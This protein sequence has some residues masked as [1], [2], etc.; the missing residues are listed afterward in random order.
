[1]RGVILELRFEGVRRFRLIRLIGVE[2][3]AVTVSV[4][5]GVAALPTWWL[6]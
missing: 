4:T 3:A 2:T 1:M 5:G 6:Y